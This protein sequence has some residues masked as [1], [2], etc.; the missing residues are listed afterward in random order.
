MRS[1]KKAFSDFFKRA[2]LCNRY[3]ILRT[4]PAIEIKKQAMDNVLKELEKLDAKK[5]AKCQSEKGQ[6]PSS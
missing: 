4:T 5:E 1:Q 2:E 6:K 3:E